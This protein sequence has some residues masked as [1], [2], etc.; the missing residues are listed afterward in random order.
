VRGL[1][2]HSRATFSPCHVVG[3][4]NGTFPGQ[5]RSGNSDVF[6]TRLSA[7]GALE[8]VV[9]FGSDRNDFGFIN[10][11]GPDGIYVNG[12]TDGRIGS[13]QRG[14]FDAFVALFHPDGSMVW[15]RQFGTKEDDDGYGLWADAS[16]VFVT[17]DTW[18]A[19]KGQR[20]L[21]GSDAYARL[22][23]PVDGSTIWTHQFGTSKS[24]VSF[25]A[26]ASDG[27]LYAVGST[28]GGF[29][30]QVSMGQTDAFVQAIDAATGQKLW[31]HQFGTVKDDDGYAGW[32]DS[33]AIYVVGATSGVFPGF[34]KLGQ[35]DAFAAR[36]DLP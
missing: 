9:Q 16:G 15:L 27:V 4:T 24:D 20:D 2:K 30:D 26:M 21:G 17:G 6:H 12:Y 32:V 22:L 3:W 25:G 28:D 34:D 5:T 18:G 14:G 36:I 35:A 29:G 10:A 1:T 33:G 13:K 11:I 7:D 8:Q 31:T 23:S 19:L